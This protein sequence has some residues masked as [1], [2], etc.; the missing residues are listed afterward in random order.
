M[1]KDIAKKMKQH[2]EIFQGNTIQ[3]QDIDH[4]LIS[5]LCNLFNFIHPFKNFTEGPSKIR[6]SGGILNITISAVLK[7]ETQESLT[8]EFRSDHL[9][10]PLAS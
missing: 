7:I 6:T 4:R 5:F 8:F 1:E 3:S 9:N 10:P 2:E